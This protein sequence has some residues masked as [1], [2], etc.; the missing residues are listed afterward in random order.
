MKRNLFI[1]A[2]ILFVSS[3]VNAQ[4]V[5][6][7]QIKYRRSSLNMILLES[8][9]FPMKDVVLGS[10][11]NYPFPNKYNNHNL[12]ERSISLESMNLTDQDL[13]ASGYL[14]DTLKTPLDIMK[15]TAK[16]QGLRY[17]N[18]DSTI[19]LALPTEKVM[20]QLKIDKILREKQIAKQVVAKWYNRDAKGVLNTQL[21]E[22]RGLFAA[23]NADVAT[24][25]TAEGG[26]A[27]LR[28]IG[29]ELIANSFTTFTKI[30]FFENEP[31]ARVIRDQAK[32]E[33]MKQLAGK[34]Q[35]LIDK[36]MQLIDAAYD[37]AKDGYTLI[38]KTWLYQ[39]DWND[40][41]LNKLYDIW[42]KPADFD[43][44]DFFK[45]KFVGSNYNTSTI[46]FSKEGRT[47]EQMIDIAL[48]R[49]IDNTF[50]KLQKEYDVF[51]PKVP[52]LS[53]DPI[54]ADIGTKE[55]IK[56]GEKFEVLELIVDPATGASEYKVVGKV[57]VDKSKVWNNEYNLNVEK[58]AE[59]D[60]DGNPIPELTST[61]FKGGGS[62]LYPGL[63]LKQVK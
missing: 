3:A 28:E 53:V 47:I 34:P 9:S 14:K 61:S 15:A 51:K 25:K 43:N 48:V 45:M 42:D 39:L 55:G 63:L 5:D 18:A 38:S 54:T 19:A 8:E 23:N 57:K 58:V 7:S 22:E 1:L 52:I 11:S 33:A 17:L 24:A 13:L 44:A 56:G 21:I 6:N 2:A 41:I 32:I 12:N 46:L 27:I 59:L 29:K 20:Y 31:V 60:K 16:L 49:N 26:E 40:T 10:W 30:D 35:V 37:K 62:K 4:K 36:S 50:A